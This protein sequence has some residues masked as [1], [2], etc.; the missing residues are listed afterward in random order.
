MHR[1]L[2]MHVKALRRPITRISSR[3][4]EFLGRA[5]I[6]YRRP[7]YLPRLLSLAAAGR[8]ARRVPESLHLAIT[9]PPNHFLR[10]NGQESIQGSAGFLSSN[11]RRFTFIWSPRRQKGVGSILHFN[12]CNWS[13]V[14]THVP[15]L[16][17]LPARVYSS[18]EPRL[19]C[20]HFLF[21]ELII[22]R[23]VSRSPSPSPL[24]RF[25]EAR[26]PSPISWTF[27]KRG[28][29]QKCKYRLQDFRSRYLVAR[30]H[31]RLCRTLDSALL[32]A[33]ISSQIDLSSQTPRNSSNLACLCSTGRSATLHLDRTIFGCLRRSEIINRTEKGHV[34]PRRRIRGC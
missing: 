10:A 28:A 30:F 12:L 5:G 23:R 3:R 1:M 2:G 34:I 8:A 17:N 11:P 18:K 24:R 32:P 33:E 9:L 27:W 7:T 13:I 25:L 29:W 16:H 21:S 15:L 26:F 20:T 4:H 31:K 6:E 22:S 14:P 19:S